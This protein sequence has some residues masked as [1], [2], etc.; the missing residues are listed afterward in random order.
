MEDGHNE[1]LRE[2]WII[3]DPGDVSDPEAEAMQELPESGVLSAPKSA[4]D[5]MCDMCYRI[6][7]TWA[8]GGYEVR[9]FEKKSIP[10]SNP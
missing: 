5:W 1:T 2:G 8:S 4:K 9:I 10:P 7:T 3:N 6:V